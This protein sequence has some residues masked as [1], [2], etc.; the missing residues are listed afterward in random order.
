MYIYIF[1]CSINLQVVIANP[2]F[3]LAIAGVSLA[4]AEKALTSDKP[5]EFLLYKTNRLHFSVCAYTAL[6]HSL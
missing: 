1:T 4:I 3:S 2:R 5:Y 6:D